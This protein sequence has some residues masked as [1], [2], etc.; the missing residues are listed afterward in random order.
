MTGNN[1]ILPGKDFIQSYKGY[2]FWKEILQSSGEAE[3]ILARRGISE[4]DKIRGMRNICIS[5][6]TFFVLKTNDVEG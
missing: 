4:A 2:E 5:S 1:S 3:R 6:C